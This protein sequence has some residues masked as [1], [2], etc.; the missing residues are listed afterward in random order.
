MHAAVLGRIKT[1][2]TVDS[3]SQAVLQNVYYGVAT[4]WNGTDFCKDPQLQQQ[5]FDD[6]FDHIIEYLKS[7]VAINALRNTT[8]G[9]SEIAKIAIGLV[10][11]LH[12][13]SYYH[14]PSIPVMREKGMIPVARNVRKE[15]D[16]AQVKTDCL[17]IIAFLMNESD[18]KTMMKITDEELTYL[19]N[20]LRNILGPFKTSG[21]HAE[22]IIDGLNRIA[23]NDSN[24]LKLMEFGILPILE[25]SLDTD[26]SHTAVHQTAAAKAVWNL[27]F[28]DQSR[29]EIKKHTKL[30]K[31]NT[32]MLICR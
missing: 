10:Q 29:Q 3:S 15:T 22:E 18:D 1:D 2:G 20:Q 31:G 14:E 13:L 7:D 16:H 30:M 9:E 32:I 19:L 4:I 17:L 24:K 8:N 26:N 11:I 27:A 12:N 28:S 5:T 25:K 23:V 6:I 21:Y